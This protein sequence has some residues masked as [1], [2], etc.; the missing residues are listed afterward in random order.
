MQIR[1]LEDSACRHKLYTPPLS[2]PDQN[3][4][5]ELHHRTEIEEVTNEFTKSLQRI[6]Q[7]FTNQLTE[8]T[9]ETIMCQCNARFIFVKSGRPRCRNEVWGR[10]ATYAGVKQ[11]L[12]LSVA[13]CTVPALVPVGPRSLACRRSEVVFSFPS[14]L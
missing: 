9:K 14:S 3:G 10:R 1:M 11:P 12:H 13:E 8:V 2:V 6:Y 5:P 7:G 4:A